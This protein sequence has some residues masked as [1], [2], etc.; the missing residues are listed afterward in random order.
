MTEQTGFP[1]DDK[2][3]Q[4]AEL[5]AQLAVAQAQQPAQAAG[6]DT[7]PQLEQMSTDRPE[8]LP[9][10]AEHD[11]L[12]AEFKAM[13]ERLAAMEGQLGQVKADYAA[14]AAK[15]GPPE[16]ATYGKNILDKLVSYRNANPDLPPGHFD[17]VIAQAGPL[18]EASQNVIDGKR[19]VSDVTGQVQ[20]T[21]DA[22]EHFVT[23]THPRKSGKP[24]DF[25]ALLTDL[26]L[27]LEAAAKINQVA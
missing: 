23:R 21:V 5:Q 2:D 9:A 10:E 22:V 7:G 16:V 6:A 12:M 18:A 17:R 13:S 24:L 15:L 25:S 26:E 3:A 11:R 8:P 4:I 27:A 1:P 19:H 14:A 20:D